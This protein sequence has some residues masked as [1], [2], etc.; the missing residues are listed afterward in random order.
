ML[1]FNQLEDNLEHLEVYHF[2]EDEMSKYKTL[3]HESI[4]W[5]KVYE[6]SLEI[7]QK[8]SMNA[9]ICNYFVLS[10]IAL[11]NKEYFEMMS[12]M[13]ENLANILQNIPENLDKKPSALNTQKK[14][15]RNTIE[16]FITESSRLNLSDFI[17][18]TTDLNHTFKLLGTILSCD[19]QEIEVKKETPKN[20]TIQSPV[21]QTES[22]IK[23]QHTNSLNDREYRIFFSNLAFEILENDKEN[24][25]AYAMFVEAMWGR[26]KILPPHNGNITQIKYPDKNLIQILLQSNDD[27]LEHTKCFMSNLVL[28]PFWIEGLKFFCEF[29]QKHK[30]N[31]ALKL[32]NILAVDFLTRFKEISNLKFING[33]SMCEEQI[34]GYFLKKDLDFNHT[35]PKTDKNKQN[36]DIGEILLDINTQNRD[37]SLFS[38]INTLIEMARMFE[39]KNMQNNARILYIQLKDLMEKTL[40]KDYL[41]EDYLEIKIKSEK[42]TKT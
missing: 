37:N 5:D 9:K 34:L 3:N 2:L 15:I 22:Q 10:C 8:F 41:P 26:I 27:E 40:L 18:I 7:L 21:Q 11:N 12:K 28:N 4:K 35:K 16:H 20:E 19:F 14:K 23:I 31:S 1:F 24:L 39:K 42:N 25:N 32:L 17:Q 38:N 30:K 13:F 33:E 29:L 36:I 6:Y